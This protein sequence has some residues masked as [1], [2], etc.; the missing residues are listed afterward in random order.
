[1]LRILPTLFTIHHTM[2]L[3]GFHLILFHLSIATHQFTCSVSWWCAGTVTTLPAAI[4]AVLVGSRGMQV[5]P[6]KKWMLLL[7]LSSFGK[8]R[9]GTGTL[10]SLNNLNNI[11]LSI[12]LTVCLHVSSDT[13]SSS[14]IYLCWFIHNTD[15]ILTGI[16]FFF[17]EIVI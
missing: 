3:L 4:K 17:N 10:V 5:L 2:M 13:K 11:R 12:L 8:L 15:I 9:L 14:E 16:F 6:S 1:M 7:D